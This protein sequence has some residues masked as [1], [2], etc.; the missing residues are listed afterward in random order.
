MYLYKEVVVTNKTVIIVDDSSASRLCLRL[1]YQEQGYRVIAEYSSVK[2]FQRNVLSESPGLLSLDYAL[3]DGTG[4]DLYEIVKARYPKLDVIF[5]TSFLDESKLMAMYE[6]G[7]L[8]ILYK[9]NLEHLSRALSYMSR[10]LRYFDEDVSSRLLEFQSLCQHLTCA[11]R[12]T[13]LALMSG[14]T[15]SFVAERLSMADRTVRSHKRRIILKLGRQTFERYCL[16]G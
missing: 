4:I 5:V 13:F 6:S 3:G 11:E 2:D 14:D 1:L 8:G 7:V 12:K 10:G 15:V 9:D 16:A